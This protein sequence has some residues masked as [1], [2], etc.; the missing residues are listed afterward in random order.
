MKKPSNGT[1][2]QSGTIFLQRAFEDF[3]QSTVKLQE[4]FTSL[5]EKFENINK[6]L[7]YKNVELERALAEKDEAKNY[8]QN[9]LKSLTT[10]IVVANIRGNVT[11]MNHY[12]EVFTGF[13]YEDARGEKA[14]SL[15]DA[16]SFYD[17]KRDFGLAIGGLSKKIRLRGRTLE[18]FKSPIKT[19]DGEEIGVVNVLCDVTRLEKLE[20]MAKRTE[21]FAAMGEMAANIAHEIRNPLGSIELFASLLKKDLKNEKNRD[22]VSHIIGSVR[23]M[24]NKI[25]NLLLFARKQKSSMKKININNVLNE[26]LKF[27]EQI[28]KKENIILTV[29]HENV[30][31]IIKGDAELLKQVFLNFILNALQAMPEGGNLHIETKVSDKTK[32]E[33]EINDSKVEIKFI[34]TGI[35]I[36]HEYIKK[37]FDPFFST[38]EGGT[39]LGLVIVHNIVDIHSGS[40]DVESNNGKGTAFNI[41]FP[42]I[43]RSEVQ[44]LEVNPY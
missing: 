27:S 35:G 5:Q 13:A 32:E 31:P 36:P 37:I 1:G 6:E 30:D 41:T 24:D 17:S 39:G 8:L 16:G 2:Q 15:F 9:I 44:R 34:D 42:L 4:A 28:I 38:R 18:V 11:M 43:K 7:E 12:A 40:I 21:K 3:S 20:E 22:R 33:R 23:N 26:V 10:G 29:N 25:S 14:E 19:N